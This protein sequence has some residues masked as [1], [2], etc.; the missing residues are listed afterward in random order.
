MPSN[1]DIGN[2]FMDKS[3]LSLLTW[4]NEKNSATLKF[5]LN[6]PAEKSIIEQF[7][8][9]AGEMLPR[10][11]VDLYECFNGQPESS[12]NHGVFFGLSFMALEDVQEFIKY[13]EPMLRDD[14]IEI[15]SQCVVKGYRYHTKWIPF[16][17]DY[18]GQYLGLDYDP[19][20]L[21]V[22][23]QVI[24]FGTSGRSFVL[25]DS[26]EGFIN[27][28]S[29]QLEEENYYIGDGI[30]HDGSGPLETFSIKTHK[31]DAFLGTLDRLFG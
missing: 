15:E 18:T 5:D 8:K 17:Q 1:R 14:D 22:K 16:A 12:D 24:N 20:D 19:G 13:V 10:A 31:Y 4:L 7:Q 28:Y 25:A 2:R 29:K 30:Y 9:E 11:L 3:V 21:G 27:W 23:G 26:F 6:S